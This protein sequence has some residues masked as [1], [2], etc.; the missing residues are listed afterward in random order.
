MT[1]DLL[2]PR[3]ALVVIDLQRGIVGSPTVPHPVEDVVR[4]NVE[5]TKAFRAHDLPVVL[6]R[7]S[8]SPDGADVAPGRST[9]SM[10]GATF[11]EGWDELIDEL[12]VQPTDIRITKRQW[13]AFYGT[14][15]DLQLRRRGITTIVLSGLATSIGVE[16]TARA[17]HEHGY[18]VVIAT[19]AVT[20]RDADAH[21]HSITKIFP[22]LGLT[23]TT[24]EVL[25]ALAKLDQQG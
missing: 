23:A 10:R 17:A 7:V 24:E 4:R 15:L 9:Q 2:D 21:T 8:F 18:H 13:G 19:D 22:R 11:P 1:S 14:D 3:T 25:D 12:D 20:D 5:L 16:S 6:V